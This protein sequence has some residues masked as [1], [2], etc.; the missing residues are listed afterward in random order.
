MGRESWHSRVMRNLR[1]SVMNIP[2]MT[3]SSDAMT[4]THNFVRFFKVIIPESAEWKEDTIPPIFR[5]A[6]LVWFT[7]GFRREGSAGSGVFCQKPKVTRSISLGTFATVF[8][9]EMYAIIE[10]VHLSLYEGKRIFILSDSQAA[11]K[12]L[13]PDNVC[14]KLTMDTIALLNHP[15]TRNYVTLGWV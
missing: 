7:D 12:A 10:S 13:Q 9:A 15:G 4:L 3:M 2:L 5:K 8:Q 1:D 14:S 6:E 11:L